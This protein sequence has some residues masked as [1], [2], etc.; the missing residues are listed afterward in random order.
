MFVIDIAVPRDVDP[1]VGEIDNVY[2]YNIDD[3]EQVVAENLELRRKEIDR[4]MEL[5]EY[6][7]NQFMQWKDTL[8]AEP[9]FVSMSEE[10]N[11]IREREL[12]RT[13]SAL[14][15]L[16]ETQRQE[17]AA[18]TKRIVKSI[19]QR[20]VVEIK[21]EIGHHDPNTVL[22]LVKRFFGLRDTT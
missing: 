20:S 9:T 4:G 11:T 14:P 1:A 16:T 21:H 15:D 10:L 12:E 19:L 5:V 8:V 18:L 22:H 7:V 13:L 2:L 3:L 6:G 17:M